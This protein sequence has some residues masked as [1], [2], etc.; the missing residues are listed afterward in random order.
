MEIDVVKLRAEFNKPHYL[1]QTSDEKNLFLRAWEPPTTSKTAIIIFHGI[2]AYSG[3]YDMI[4]IP[5][6][7]AGF[8]I[9]GLDLRGHGL[10]DGKRGD[11]PSKTRLVNDICET[12]NFVKKQ[13]FSE[14]VLLGHSLGNMVALEA[15]DHCKEHVSGLILLSVGRTTRPGAYAKMSTGQKLKTVAKLIFAY[16]RPVIEY[17]RE[18]MTGTNDPLFNFKYTPRFL[19]ILNAQKFTEKY[20]FPEQLNFPVFVGI[21]EHDEIF[22]VETA[23]AFFDEVPSENK[24]FQV[25]PGAKH[26]EY[27]KGSWTSL[28]TW[29]KKNFE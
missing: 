29:L 7:D 27:P 19:T 6:S 18:G 10:S 16:N 13:G 20:Q 11:Y 25:I 22:S 3:P 12:I 5:V 2:T 24:E 23:H 17:E 8:S 14:I 4:G 15:L 26:A 9:F 28:I 21:G 1:I